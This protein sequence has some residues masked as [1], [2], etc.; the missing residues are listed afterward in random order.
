MT[1]KVL[2]FVSVVLPNLTSVD[3]LFLQSSAE[4]F[5]CQIFDNLR[6]LG[7]IEGEYQCQRATVSIAKPPASCSNSSY[8]L[9]LREKLAIAFGVIIGLLILAALVYLFHWRRRSGC[10]WGRFKQPEDIGKTMER[11]RNDS[12]ASE[13]WFDTTLNADTRY[14]YINRNRIMDRATPAEGPDGAGYWEVT[15][16]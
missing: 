10:C 11:G 7:I 16:L 8:G 13:I 14:M 1:Q 2:I 15:N 12:I 5:N 6:C 9:T 4:D 3:N